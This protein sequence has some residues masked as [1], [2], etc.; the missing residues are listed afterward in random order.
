MEDANHF[1]S[2]E[3]KDLFKEFQTSEKGLSSEETSK[4]LKQQGLNQISKEKKTPLIFRL[5]K[6]FHSPL[7]YILLIAMIISFVFN[8]LVDAYVIIAVI[9]INVSISFIQE[10]KAERA[11]EALEKLIISYAKVLRNG[12][13]I[14]IPSQNLVEGDIIILEEGDKVPADA[15]LIE[16]KNFRTQESSLTG[17]SFPEEKTLKILDKSIPLPDRINMVFMSTLVV[18]GYA[19][20]LVVST[21]NRTQIGQVAESIQEIAQPKMHFNKKVSQLAYQM[22]IFAI[23]GALLTFL[24]GFFIRGLEFFEIFL[25]TIASLVSGI[26]EGLPAVLIIVLAVG[27][28]RMAKRNAVIRH[29]P[30]VETLGVATVIATDKTGTLTQNSITVEE[31][32]T[33]EGNFSVTGNGWEPLGKF[34]QNKSAINPQKFS[35][36]KKLFEISEFCNKGKLL[37]KNSE[38]EII[39]DPTEVSLL[40]LSKKSGLDKKDFK[41]KIIDDLAF[42][43]ELKFRATLVENQNKQVF[44]L[45]AFEK[46]LNKSNYIFKDNKKIHLTS[47]IKKDFLK[48]AEQLAKKGMRVLA[49]G[50]KDVNSN[51]TSVSKELVNNLVFVGIVGM[52]DPPRKNIK[53][54][55]NKAR[56]AGIRIIMKTGDHKET[57]L[58]IAKEIGLASGKTEVL[59]ENDLQ[60]LNAE[61]FKQAVKR[62]DI[63]ARVTPKT[64]AKIVQ[65]LQE[66]GEIVAMTGDGVNDAPALK[67]S[68]IGIAMGIIGT[69]VARESAEI[70]LADDNFISIVNAIEEGRIVFQNVRQTSFF[71]VTTNVAEDITIISS[72]SLGM[73]LPM[74]PIQLL[75]LNLVTD[76]FNGIGLAMEPGHHDVLN[77][78]PRNKKE[79]ILNKELI[80]FLLIMGG[81]MVIGTI[82]LF[83][84]FLSHSVDKARTVAFTAMSM[85]Q[86]FNVFNMRSLHK[87]IFKIKLFSNKY[88]IGGLLA[89]FL[90]L[91]V[92]IYT[93]LANIFNFVPLNLKEFLLIVL[94]SS[95]VL[96]VGEIY[97]L[98]VHKE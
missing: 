27:A 30:A 88:L 1:H 78:P 76:T 74:L 26:P 55:I 87:S 29:L 73:P 93:P 58:A 47:E 89:S 3:I 7:T 16:I 18:S 41:T 80:G 92:V 60:K 32:I 5:L 62:V 64:K 14:K 11:I 50:Y 46:I 36:L 6:Q 48:Q 20:A 21:G 35:S 84:H 67:R 83:K 42:S 39:G 12:E 31:I 53:E 40:V 69:D 71:L 59:T 2:K 72:L 22:G 61:E 97:K 43:S 10:R 44:S 75:Y 57:A 54:S 9:L 8:H 24:I 98:I 37:R 81:L 96:F 86:L 13:E 15:R 45:G 34:F 90:L 94:I 49:L 82:P 17:E 51:T 38:Y 23:I 68:D 70:V 52:K 28:N 65:T 33:S 77:K 79:K 95:S 56:K 85:F 66:Q 4:R 63:F 91:L 25:F 19:K